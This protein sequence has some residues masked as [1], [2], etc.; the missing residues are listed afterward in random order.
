MT[1]IEPRTQTPERMYTVTAIAVSEHI[2]LAIA[3]ARVRSGPSMPWSSI[4]PTS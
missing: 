2:S 4:I 3:A 1:A